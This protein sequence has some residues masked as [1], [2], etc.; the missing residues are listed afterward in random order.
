MVTKKT[1]KARGTS[2]TVDPGHDPV[3]SV[4]GKGSADIE[5]AQKKYVKEVTQ[6][7]EEATEAQREFLNANQGP[8]GKVVALF[9]SMDKSLKQVGK[10]WKALG[11]DFDKTVK[12][13]GKLKGETLAAER[14]LN[15][16][17]AKRHKAEKSTTMS[18]QEQVAQIGYIL[19]KE[20]DLNQVLQKKKKQLKDTEKVLDAHNVAV[21][22]HG[23]KWGMIKKGML[24]AA[25][26]AAGVLLAGLQKVVGMVKKVA[27]EWHAFWEKFNLNM[28]QATQ[29][30][31]DQIGPQGVMIRGMKKMAKMTFWKG[32]GMEEAANVTAKLAENMDMA[33]M[34]DKTAGKWIKVG[35]LASKG[36]GMG[37]EAA[38]DFVGRLHKGWQMTEIDVTKYI[39]NIREAA[40]ETGTSSVLMGKDISDTMDIWTKYG[41]NFESMSIA[42][43]R[44][45]RH[46]GV[47]LKELLAVSDKF[48]TFESASENVGKLNAVM[49]LNL[50]T[51]KML[52]AT[53]TE[54]ADILREE[55]LKSGKS[56][57]NMNRFEREATIGLTGW[58]AETAQAVLSTGKHHKSLKELEREEEKRARQQKK[59]SAVQKEANEALAEMGHILEEFYGWGGRIKEM[60]IKVGEVFSPLI[61]EFRS[62]GMEIMNDI[63]KKIGDFDSRKL[64][65]WS[66]SLGTSLQ[67]LKPLFTAVTD[68]MLGIGSW[69]ESDWSGVGILVKLFEAIGW[70]AKKAHDKILILERKLAISIMFGKKGTAQNIAQS[71]YYT[72]D[73]ME[74]QQFKNKL[75]SGDQALLAGVAEEARHRFRS[76]EGTAYANIKGQGEVLEKYIQ[77]IL[78]EKIQEKKLEEQLKKEKTT[79]GNVSE[80]LAEGST[81]ANKNADIVN[82]LAPGQKSLKSV[83]KLDDY[84]DAGY[85]MAKKIAKMEDG[86]LI[87]AHAKLALIGAFMQPAAEQAGLVEAIQSVKTIPDTATTSKVGDVHIM[88]APVIM[89]GQ[90]VGKVVAAAIRKS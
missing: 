36:L 76:G 67:D 45:A 77:E 30:L 17:L 9:G 40:K 43:A 6:A 5:R 80:I 22:K 50:N 24:G 47:S 81:K 21:Q 71:E 23:S 75:D 65:E 39:L 38:G 1:R 15:K 32:W 58:N 68:W 62:F 56:W 48:T 44:R 83:Q 55:L 73:L 25:A 72:R 13:A 69:K 28:I 14:D 64:V 51:A 10:D 35:V 37:A 2:P 46:F 53:E 11:T 66:E 42:G 20:Q 79:Q 86:I 74:T 8:L 78:Q 57:Q 18:K 88:M 31:R 60:F 19:K 29:H 4:R 3:G 41:K 87:K 27:M 54:R 59:D 26:V 16:L 89:D 12:K 82:K 52:L 49:G 63:M 85:K 7:Y 70:A 34:T 33:Q 90:K 61:K 84:Y